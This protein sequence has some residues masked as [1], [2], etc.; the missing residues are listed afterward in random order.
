MLP[1]RAKFPKIFK[2]RFKKFDLLS[3]FMILIM[4]IFH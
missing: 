4:N 1:K 2:K 3:F